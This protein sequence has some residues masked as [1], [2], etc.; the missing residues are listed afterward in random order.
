MKPTWRC[1]H[2]GERVVGS[3]YRSPQCHSGPIWRRDVARADDEI[4]GVGGNM[5]GIQR[6]RC[7]PP[8]FSLIQNALKVERLISTGRRT[9]NGTG[10][11][12]MNAWKAGAAI[13]IC[14]QGISEEAC[15]EFAPAAPQ[16]IASNAQRGENARAA[17]RVTIA[18]SRLCVL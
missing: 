9:S 6:G 8:S 3:C 15:S 5:F 14:L 18:L 13:C 7:L 10:G 4:W 11:S 1:A 12:H 16:R 2:K 17:M